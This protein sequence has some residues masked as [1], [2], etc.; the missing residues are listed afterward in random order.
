M[1][2]GKI[3]NSIHT[4]RGRKTKS[5]KND[6][7][8]KNREFCSDIRSLF[9]YLVSLIESNEHCCFSGLKKFFQEKKESD[10]GNDKGY[11]CGVFCNA[12]RL[13]LIRKKLDEIE[14]NNSNSRK[15]SEII[16]E[17]KI[18]VE[19]IKEMAWEMAISNVNLIYP[20][21]SRFS[22]N[23]GGDFD[24][25]LF[26]DLTG[27]GIEG[28]LRATYYYDGRNGCEFSTYANWWIRQA[29][30]RSL[31]DKYGHLVRLPVHV[32][33]TINQLLKVEKSL[34]DELESSVTYHDI[35]MKTGV[36]VE[37]ISIFLGMKIIYW[38]CPV[39]DGSDL[40]ISE[41]MCREYNLS[42]ELDPEVKM[43]GKDLSEKVLKVLSTLTSREEQIIR[44]RFGIGGGGGNTL[45]EM[46]EKFNVTRE[47]IRQLEG[48]ALKT[49]RY[50]FIENKLTL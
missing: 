2:E 16:E 7:S 43:E 3:E 12:K 25:C 15:I 13:A 45:D 18:V 50:R 19:L 24:K 36:P 26:D 39:N 27:E 17:A 10:A 23:K 22:K 41:N 47:R 21:A 5:E 48:K 33:E 35:S 6:F 38:D 20:I 44:G 29:I 1:F 9:N 4:K 42:K 14:H 40:P 30:T 37:T 34:S 46:G 32:S 11:A 28:L 8:V 31:M 49:L